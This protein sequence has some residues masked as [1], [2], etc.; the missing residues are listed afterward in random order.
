MDSIWSVKLRAKD[1]TELKRLI[2]DQHLDISCNGPTRSQDDTFEVI[3]YVNEDQKKGLLNKRSSSMSV[4]VLENMT[5]SGIERQ[6]DVSKGQRFKD[7]AALKV[8][9]LGIKE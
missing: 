7:S 1:K 2:F 3:A 8:K 9:G 4:E 6:K 5:Q